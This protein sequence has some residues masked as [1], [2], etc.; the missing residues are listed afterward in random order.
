VK[1]SHGLMPPLRWHAAA[2]GDCLVRL[3]G[4]SVPTEQTRLRLR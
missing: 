2:G 3:M 4:A 1:P